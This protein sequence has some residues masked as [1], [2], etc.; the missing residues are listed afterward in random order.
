MKDITIS[1]NTDQV[2]FEK[3]DGVEGVALYI[4]DI[5][6]TTISEKSANER[7]WDEVRNLGNPAAVG[8]IYED[9]EDV[10]SFWDK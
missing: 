6:V 4:N 9:G 1:N 2:T 5:Y 7:G 10:V 3:E 8:C